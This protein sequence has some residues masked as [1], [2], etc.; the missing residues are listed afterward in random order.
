MIYHDLGDDELASMLHD[1][2]TAWQAVSAA[3]QESV[4]GYPDT[5]LIEVSITSNHSLGH[6][7]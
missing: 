7:P 3:I 1:G 2:D 4:R 5:A 6:T